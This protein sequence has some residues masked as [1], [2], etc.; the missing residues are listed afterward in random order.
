MI[1]SLPAGYETQIG[2]GGGS[3]SGGQRQRIALAARGLWFA[4]CSD[5]G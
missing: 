2:S 1:L 5:P 4:A 3:L